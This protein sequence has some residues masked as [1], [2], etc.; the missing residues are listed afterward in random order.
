[1]SQKLRFETRAIRSVSHLPESKPVSPPIH[2]SS[3]YERS[4]DGGYT[5]DFIYSRVSNPNRKA[6]ENS[7]AS[8]EGGQL[9]LAFSS[10]MAAI[11]AVFQSLKPGDHVII[12]DDVYYAIYA[13]LSEVFKSW[14]LEFTLVNMADVREVKNSIRTNTTLIWIET[15]SNPQLKLTD[16]SKIASIAKE[17]NAL[18]AVDNTW[19]TPVL[20]RPIEYGAD[21]VVH[22]TTKYFGGHSDVL[23]G[24]VVFKEQNDFANKTTSIQTLAGAVPSPFDCWLISRGIMTLSLRV[25]AQTESAMKLALFLNSHPNVEQVN[26]PGLEN[27]PQHEIAKK[28]MHGGYGAMLS[29]LII[30]NEQL[31]MKVASK[32]QLFTSATSLG[33]VESLVEH[34]K[35]V[36]GPN[37]KTPQNL[38]RISIGLEN[39][40][41]LI[42]DWTQALK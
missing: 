23:S 18:L 9:C 24:C 6:L 31:A 42:E 38:L 14:N 16:I 17:N 26:Y 30:G 4:D 8:L 22:S 15:P 33:G 40:N 21:I 5:N 39:V 36:E 28:Q 10:G 11:S 29:I 12:P 1:M 13:L 32:L 35:S 37:S 41:D 19:P 3:T 2:L 20:T 34:R 27:H 7:I 25:K